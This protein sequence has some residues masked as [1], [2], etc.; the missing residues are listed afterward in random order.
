MHKQII[1]PVHALVWLA[2]AA[3]SWAQ[4]PRA[5]PVIEEIIV[6][7]EKS[8]RELSD[9]AVSITA[10]AGDVLEEFGIA[11]LD[12]YAT[13][14]PGFSGA[15]RGGPVADGGVR[16]AGLRGVQSLN[17]ARGSGQNT[18]GYYIGS[19]PVPLSNPRLVD[20]DRVEVLRGPQGTLYGANSLVGTVKLV[21]RLPSTEKVAYSASASVRSVDK[22]GESLDFEGYFNVP[23]AEGV[24]LRASGFYEERGG[25]I[26]FEEMQA[27]PELLNLEVPGVGSFPFPRTTSSP[28]GHVDSDSNEFTTYGGRAAL[29][30]DVNDR[31]AVRPSILYSKRDLDNTETLSR[32]SEAI[33]LP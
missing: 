16:V 9:T 11:D 24:A 3:G 31:F 29:Q 20:V 25:Y 4:A 22:G 5:A 10:L 1:V 21:P 8:Q 18:V 32:D 28:T 14:V 27:G 12:G 23:L 26:D 13:L 30:I 2:A 6:T 19:T 15:Y 33:A 7:A 17:D